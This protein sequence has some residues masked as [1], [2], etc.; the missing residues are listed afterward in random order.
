MLILFRA[1]LPVT[2]LPWR[3]RLGA[4]TAAQSLLQPSAPAGWSGNQERHQE[5]GI[6]KERYGP[7]DTHM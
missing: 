6:R 4:L 2:R 1:A 5:G 3:L 7:H